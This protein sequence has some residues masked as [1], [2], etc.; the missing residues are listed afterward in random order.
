M[1]SYI[2]D[3]TYF[4]KYTNREINHFKTSN[5]ILLEGIDI[6]FSDFIKN[7]I[8]GL[9]KGSTNR[10]VLYIGKISS[11]LNDYINSKLNNYTKNL[12][13]YNV[14]LDS[15]R[16]SHIINKHGDKYKES[17][18]GQT[19]ILPNTFLIL[20]FIISHADVIEHSIEKNGNNGLKFIKNYKNGVYNACY[21][22]SDKNKKL[23]LSTLYI[24]KKKK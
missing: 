24:N 8:K 7:S 9:Y 22:I 4:E 21:F 2:I 10:K 12:T 18:L 17:L 20:P 5:T 19:A 1:K 15:D 13:N 11:K 14:I 16:I 3:I 23:T 6:L